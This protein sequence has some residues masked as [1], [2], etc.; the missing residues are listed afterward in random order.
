MPPTCAQRTRAHQQIPPHCRRVELLSN[1]DRIRQCSSTSL[2]SHRLFS[3]FQ[4]V[5]D[6]I[7]SLL[8]G[9]FAPLNGIH[10]CGVRFRAFL[11]EQILA[12]L[13]LLP[14]HRARLHAGPG[15]EQ[16]TCRRSDGYSP[17]EMM[18]HMVS[19]FLGFNWHAKNEDVPALRRALPGAKFSSTN[20]PFDLSL[21]IRSP[22]AEHKG[23]PRLLPERARVWIASPLRPSA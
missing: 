14:D 2:T 6:A 5:R 9:R 16:N 8:Q 18:C 19:S 23:P 11:F 21:V 13:S 3:G 22:L 17:K 15:R 10:R 12:F 20:S 4:C 7:G 1:I